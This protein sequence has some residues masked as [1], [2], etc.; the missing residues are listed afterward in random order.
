MYEEFSFI[1]WFKTTNHKDVGILYIVTSIFFIAI[2]G[3]LGL[4]MRAQLWSPMS[5]FISTFK[6]EQAVTMHGLIMILWF[7]SPLGTGI[8]NYLVPIQIGAKDMA[9][10]RLNALSYWL[11]LF[12]G[13]ILASTFFLPGG[14]PAAGWTM[15]APLSGIQFSPQPGMTVSILAV[16][17]LA[18]SITI[19]SVNFITTILATREKGM[20]W[21][22]VPPFSWAVFYTNALML[23]AFPPL[24]VGTSLLTTD[25]LFGTVFFSSYQGGSILWDNFFWFFGHP[26]VYIVV[27]PVLG[28]LAEVIMTFSDNPLF[29][30]NVFLLEIGLVTILSAYVWVHHM[31]ETGINYTVRTVFSFSTM[32]ISIPFEGIVLSLILTMRNGAVK[33]KM[34]MLL[35]LGAIFFVTLGGITGVF[36]ASIL[37]DYAFRG[38][39]WV[40]GH[41]HYVMV[42]T[43]IFGLFAGLYYWFP[44][45]TGKL[46]NEKYLKYLFW[47][48]FIGFNVLYLP[49][50][51]LLKMPRRVGNYMTFPE[52]TI[53]NRIATVGAW[54][55]GP[56]LAIS[57]IFLLYSV[58][59]SKPSKP[60]PWGSKSPEWFRN[61]S[62]TEEKFTYLPFIIS[63]S[64][65]LFII[66]LS[67]SIPIMILGLAIIG[68]SMVTWFHHD[69][70]NLYA[71]FKTT[72]N[73]KW[74]FQTVSKEKLGVF[75]F[76]ASE[77]VVFGGLIGG[78][79][80][81]RIRSA[82]WPDPFMTHNLSI[83]VT[84]TFILLMSSLTMVLAYQ[85][86]KNGNINGLKFWL[87]STLVLGTSFEVLK[88]GIEWPQEAAKGFIISGGLPQTTYYT[89]MGAHA[90]HVGI[91]L[92]AISYLIVKVFSN[93][94]SISSHQSVELIGIYWAF[95]D[96]VWMFL[97]PLFYLL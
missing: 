27:L 94:F 16:A 82:S 66:G 33:L 75:V 50:F 63:I 77:V 23:V 96:M 32:A 53:F 25:R 35:S 69:V 85:A 43:T 26:E 15:Y 68:G 67:L 31:F 51:F 55:F 37:L 71:E 52:L 34:P 39:Y 78:Y 4:L 86:I 56:G 57:A 28:I 59:K 12:S 20:T 5:T 83:G 1:K 74:P 8:S 54:V 90:L 42:G 14:A 7:L 30:R 64:V 80:Y 81:V 89:V 48:D 72:V 6:Y 9:F 91:G 88:L 17:M 61:S 60:N 93:K 21:D 70:N 45:I 13:L 3:S 18:S 47:V 29:A 65:S 19:S 58:Y 79:L 24:L 73:E 46:Y 36:Q 84:N 44:K 76:L 62:E 92:A 2:G 95:V 11:Y 41:F 22:K 38:T 10:P 87:I 49:Y 40:V 97:F